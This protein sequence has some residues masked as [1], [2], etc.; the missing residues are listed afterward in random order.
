[1]RE[2]DQW[3]SLWVGLS[4]VF[5]LLVLGLVGLL[6]WRIQGRSKLKSPYGGELVPATQLSFAALCEVER[7][8]QELPS[9]CKKHFD[10]DKSMVCRAS[11]RLL[12]TV[13][14]SSVK[15]LRKE[16]ILHS[17]YPGQ[18]V[19]WTSLVQ[20][21]REKVELNFQ[22][23]DWDKMDRERYLEPSTGRVSGW[24][25]IPNTDLFFPVVWTPHSH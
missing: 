10:V 19:A 3:V 15:R 25:R 8:T 23:V 6:A 17:I 9:N 16:N 14:S 18:W 24:H 4:T 21:Q 5:C 2:V 7:F 13:E 12:L 22:G 20:G 1:M 11:G